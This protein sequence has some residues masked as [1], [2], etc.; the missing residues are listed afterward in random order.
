MGLSKGN[1]QGVL[2]VGAHGWAR[3][4]A[5]ALRDLGLDVLMVDTNHHET[6]AARIEGLPAYYGN[7]LSEDFGINAPLDGIGHL[8]A[9]TH[10]DEVNALVCLEFASTLGRSNMFQ[11]VPDDDEPGGEE[12]PM[13]LR[14]QAL[15]GEQRTYWNLESRFR[16]GAVVKATRLGEEFGLEEFRA[17]YEKNGSEAIPVFVYTADKKLRVVVAGEEVDAGPGDT[18]IAVVEDAK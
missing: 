17:T 2:F 12:L 15:F 8:L 7:A 5:R 11:L 13:H 6:Q 16:A 4:F 10:N 9:L 18:L 1:P 3:Q 14:G